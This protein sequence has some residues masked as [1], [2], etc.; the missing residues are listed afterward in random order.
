MVKKNPCV[1]FCVDGDTD[2]TALKQP[3]SELFENTYGD[4]IYVDFRC[5]MYQNENHG[6]IT[7]LSGVTPEKIESAIK[8]YYFKKQDK[9]S[10]PGWEDV[11]SI[12][13][14][15]D[16]DGAYITREEDVRIF[17]EDELNLANQMSRPKRRVDTLYF[18]DHIAVREN[19]Q[20]MLDRN[21]RKRQNIEYLLS[22]DEITVGKKKIRYS[23]YYFSSNMDHFIHGK[24]NSTDTEKYKNATYFNDFNSTAENFEYAIT[25][26]KY[27][28]T[29]DYW[30]SWKKI[31]QANNSLLRGTNINILLDRIKNSEIGDW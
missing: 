21:Q 6:D 23:L 29:D 18:D 20:W 7:T 4:D 17:S 5:A 30:G 3:I 26:N 14:I 9:P 8:K 10:N 19:P 25:N 27:C 13:H 2:I 28:T 22:L 24:A 1:F 16:L 11:T 15:I 31:K 12:V